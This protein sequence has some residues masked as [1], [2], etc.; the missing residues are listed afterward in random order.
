MSTQFLMT[1]S[2][3]L[4]P[5]EKKLVFLPISRKKGLCKRVNGGGHFRGAFSCLPAPGSK[6]GCAPEQCLPPDTTDLALA[7]SG[8]SLLLSS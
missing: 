1:F 3:P 4:P 8:R 5:G 7:S 6:T 2:P